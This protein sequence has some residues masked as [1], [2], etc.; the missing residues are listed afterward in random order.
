M[1]LHVVGAKLLRIT[2]TELHPTTNDNYDLSVLSI[3]ISGRY[4][5]PGDHYSVW[6]NLWIPLCQCMLE[7]RPDLKSYVT[8]CIH[9][10]TF[11]TVIIVRTAIAYQ[12]HTYPCCRSGVRDQW[13]WVSYIDVSEYWSLTFYLCGQSH[14]ITWSD[15]NNLLGVD[16]STKWESHQSIAEISKSSIVANVADVIGNASTRQIVKSLTQWAC[17][18]SLIYSPAM[19]TPEDLTII[20]GLRTWQSVTER[21]VTS[22]RIWARAAFI[23]KASSPNVEINVKLESAYGTEYL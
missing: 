13:V 17:T 1:N 14:V 20:S 10:Q 12:T 19:T 18:V 22:R 11:D 23:A 8:A 21:A 3:N 2:P 4:W 6:L 7:T 16:T 9:Q 15:G 5:N